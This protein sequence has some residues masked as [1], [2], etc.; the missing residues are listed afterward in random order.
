MNKKFKQYY[1]EAL[2]MLCESPQFT[3]APINGTFK[4]KRSTKERYRPK[5]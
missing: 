4:P 3:T 1:L 2:S 5:L